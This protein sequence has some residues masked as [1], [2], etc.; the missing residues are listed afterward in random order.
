MSGSVSLSDL[1]RKSSPGAYPGGTCVA[2]NVMWYYIEGWW[3]PDFGWEYY[4]EYRH[5]NWAQ[6]G[7]WYYMA[8]HSSDEVNETVP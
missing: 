2:Q 7:T 5:Y 4:A 8:E 6:A 3:D 1:Y